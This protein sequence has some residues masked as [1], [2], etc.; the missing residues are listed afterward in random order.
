LTAK[1]CVNPIA[2]DVPMRFRDGREAMGKVIVRGENVDVALVEVDT[3]IA[4]IARA[5]LNE[6]EGDRVCAVGMPMGFFEWSYTCGVISAVRMGAVPGFERF[7]DHPLIQVDAAGVNGGNSG[8]PLFAADGR[9]VGIISWG[10]LLPHGT[11][12]HFAV[13]TWKARLAVGL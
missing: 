12:I 7:G 1:H 11:G 6:F 2:D 10:V 3:G 13:P 5:S 8:G 9:L 4:P